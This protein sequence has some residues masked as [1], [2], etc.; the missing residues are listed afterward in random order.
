MESG[1]NPSVGTLD[2]GVLG[3]I[4]WVWSFVG[5]KVGWFDKKVVH[6]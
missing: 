5:C 3:G 4:L 6:E 2:L 1:R